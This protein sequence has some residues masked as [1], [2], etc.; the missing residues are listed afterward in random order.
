MS[1]SLKELVH[2]NI[3]Y[4]YKDYKTPD[5]WE[6]SCIIPF[7]EFMSYI[8]KGYITSYDGF[9]K[10]LYRNRVLKDC[11]LFLMCGDPK[12]AHIEFNGYTIRLRALAEIFKN[13][14]SIMWYNK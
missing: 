11:K 10:L 7:Q 13:D 1:C 5:E 3:F 9:G 2:N 4:N 6:K 14:V 8:E 12:K